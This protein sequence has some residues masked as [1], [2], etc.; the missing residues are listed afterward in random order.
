MTRRNYGDETILTLTILSGTRDLKS[1]PFL[2]T[3]KSKRASATAGAPASCTK[4]QQFAPKN[5]ATEA[6]KVLRCVLTYVARGH[7][8]CLGLWNPQ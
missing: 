8:T 4:N 2:Y 6:W 7:R 3:A 1:Q 5:E